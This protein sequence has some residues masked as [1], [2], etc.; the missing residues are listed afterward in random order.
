MNIFLVLCSLIHVHKYVHTTEGLLTFM[1][2][3]MVTLP[4]KGFLAQAVPVHLRGIGG[5]GAPHEFLFQRR[6]NCGF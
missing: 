4:R 2:A 3:F 6:C 5:P 1:A